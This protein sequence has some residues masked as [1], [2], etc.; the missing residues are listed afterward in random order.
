MTLTAL[1]DIP[2]MNINR[3]NLIYGCQLLGSQISELESFAILDYCK[4]KGICKFD[5]AE[6][7]PFPEKA[8]TVGKS[9]VIFG[10]WLKGQD[11]DSVSIA[12][13]VT[14]RNSEGW[15]GPNSMRL[16]YDR[17][18]SAIKNSLARLCT[19]YIDIF[20]L[21]WPDR[22]TNNFG[23]KYYNP[24]PDPN[25]VGFD[26][27]FDALVDAQKAG[28]INA[29]G[30]A[31]ETPW[32]LMRFIELNRKVQLTIHVQ[33]AFSLINRNIELAMKEIILRENLQFQAH[34]VLAGGLLSGKY[35]VKNGDFV[36][37]GRISTL[38]YET[39]KLREQ[40]IL[41]KYDVIKMYAIQNNIDVYKLATSFISSQAFV[42]EIILG[43]STTKQLEIVLNG[44]LKPINREIIDKLGIQ[45]K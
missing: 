36:G 26:E 29:I 17:I 20:F 8:T 38:K 41:E 7:Y 27:Q 14:G 5:L 35:E 33:D 23:R 19:D 43:A 39:R 24:D 21:H 12:T 13:K 25:F 6:R 42:N 40:Q 2:K 15:F 3:K 1:Q 22:Y 32:G 45:L 37:R 16:S 10:K 31:N 34:S 30:F 9:E 28:E 44:I 18:R 11:R 4:R